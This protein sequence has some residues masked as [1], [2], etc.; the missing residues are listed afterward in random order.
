MRAVVCTTLISALMLAAIGCASDDGTVTTRTTTTSSDDPSGSHDATT[1]LVG[2]Q[3][4]ATRS[5]ALTKGDRFTVGVSAEGAV[6]IS[7]EILPGKPNAG[8][9]TSTNE[10]LF[11]AATHAKNAVTEPNTEVGIR[12]N[13][14]DEIVGVWVESTS[15]E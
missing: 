13:G 3:K 5:I 1:S 6:R 14:T 7:V 2:D 10:A 8:I 9:Y 11:E 12:V 15:N 4:D